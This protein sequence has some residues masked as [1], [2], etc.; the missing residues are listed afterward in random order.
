MNAVTFSP[1][2]HLVAAGGT[3]GT[4]Q[5]WN[6]EHPTAAASVFRDEKWI[7]SLTFSPDGKL[8]AAGYNDGTV[9]LRNLDRSSPGLSILYGHTDNVTSVAFSPDGRM[10]ASG[11]SDRTIIVRILTPILADLVCQKVW[12]NLTQEEWNQFI[13]TDIPYESTCPNLPPRNLGE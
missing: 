12:R 3:R 6:L 13:S 1:D 5:I 4:I 7:Q 11:G 9:R 2:G 8:L 10:L